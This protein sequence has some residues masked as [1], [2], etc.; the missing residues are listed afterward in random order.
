MIII[1]VMITPALYSWFNIPGFWD[2]YEHTENIG[3][4]IVNE[5]KGA[6][7]SVTGSLNIGNQVVKQLKQNHELGWQFPDAEKADRD[8]KRGRVY[9]EITIPPN[10]SQEMVDLIQGQGHPAKLKY[11]A[12]QKI[13]AISPHITAQ[14]A[15]GIDGQIS[16]SFNKEIAKAVTEEVKEAGGLLQGRFDAARLNSADAFQDVADAVAN[17]RDEVGAIQEQIG[18]LQPTI[19]QIKKT[20]GSVDTALD[21]AQDA[22]TQ[23]QA[24]TGELTTRS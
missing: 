15:S 13:N 2:P 11:R 6:S 5:D 16:A 9:A 18:D 3:V 4:A 19:A 20:L 24:I 12:N 17:S 22:L 7:S 21:D 14:G 1:G 23:V 10:F 8:L